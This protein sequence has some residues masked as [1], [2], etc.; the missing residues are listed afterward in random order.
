MVIAKAFREGDN[1]F[2][3]TADPI[4]LGETRK[5]KYEEVERHLYYDECIKVSSNKQEIGKQQLMQKN[6][7]A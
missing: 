4:H 3:I 2:V 7:H 1:N 6:H 5:A